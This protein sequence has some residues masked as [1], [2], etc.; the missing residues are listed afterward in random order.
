MVRA[1]IIL[2]LAVVPFNGTSDKNFL[3]IQRGVQRKIL[4]DS[5]THFSGSSQHMIINI[6]VVPQVSGVSD[7]GVF[8]FLYVYTFWMKSPYNLVCGTNMVAVRM[9]PNIEFKIILC[10]T[11]GIQVSD[12]VI[13]ISM[14]LNDSGTQGISRVLSSWKIIVF[15]GINHSELSVAF[16]KNGFCVVRQREVVDTLILFFCL[17]RKETG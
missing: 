12:D 14:S 2:I 15:S 5:C 16:Q 6:E 4:Y 11:N 3:G 17:Y 9:G 8:V 13:F 1:E 10:N 7:I